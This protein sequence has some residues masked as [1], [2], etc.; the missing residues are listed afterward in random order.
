MIFIDRGGN[1][2]PDDLQEISQGL[3]ASAEDLAVALLGPPPRKGGSQWR[4]GR[5]GSLA[6]TVRGRWRGRWRDHEAGAGGDGIALIQRERGCSF[7]DALAWARSYLGMP[8]RESRQGDTGQAEA[9][10]AERERI[11]SE[12]KAVQAAEAEA[13]AAERTARAQAFWAA[14]RPIAGTVAETYLNRA[15]AIPTPRQGCPEALR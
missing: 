4:Y 15:R 12:R 7:P 10:R 14:G 8:E 1:A 9:A 6:V 5:K 13:E 11:A 3:A 2:A